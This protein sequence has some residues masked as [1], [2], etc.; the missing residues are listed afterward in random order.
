MELELARQLLAHEE[1][2]GRTREE[3]STAGG[4]VYD[5][6][7]THLAPLIGAMGVQALLARSVRLA[8]RPELASLGEVSVLRGSPKLR[9]WLETQDTRA[10]AE[11]VA[12]VFGTFF[13]LLG[14]FIGERLTL[15]ILRNA[16][17]TLE[18][19]AP[20]ETKK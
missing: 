18:E 8:A 7:N 1:A 3:A 16:W 9:D 19:L 2:I 15:Q 20:N 14:K 6:L 10:V 17:P 5:K 11:S 13:S 4:R 12:V